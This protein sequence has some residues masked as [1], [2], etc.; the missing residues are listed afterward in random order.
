MTSLAPRRAAP[1]AAA[2]PSVID[3]CFFFM[4]LFVGLFGAGASARARAAR[5]AAPRRGARPPVVVPRRVVPIDPR[6]P[7]AAAR[8]PRMLTAKAAALP[9]DG[10]PEIGPSETKSDRDFERRVPREC[11]GARDCE[12]A[13]K[14]TKNRPRD[15]PQRRTIVWLSPWSKLQ[16]GPK[17]HQALIRIS[18]KRNR[19]RATTKNNQIFS[20]ALCRDVC[21]SCCRF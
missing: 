14:A 6:R 18:S 1:S 2:G 4:G 16:S 11:P 21:I 17:L 12:P 15:S 20:K 5:L 10:Q 9:P 13:P 7:N 8:R 3:F 19:G